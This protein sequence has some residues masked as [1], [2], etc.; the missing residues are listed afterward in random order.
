MDRAVRPTVTNRLSDR[1]RNGRLVPKTSVSAFKRR[2]AT[3]LFVS[4]SKYSARI[5]FAAKPKEL[6]TRQT[7]KLARVM[8]FRARVSDA[9]SVRLLLEFIFKLNTTSFFSKPIRL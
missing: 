3:C 1:F 7:K 2:T 5:T 9:I 4:D 8:Q 6:R